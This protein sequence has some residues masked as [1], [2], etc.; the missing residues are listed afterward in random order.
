MQHV[1]TATAVSA[2]PRA[3]AAGAEIAGAPQLLLSRAHKVDDRFDYNQCIEE[4]DALALTHLGELKLCS[5]ETAVA[6]RG[7]VA[8]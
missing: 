5:L 7:R 1:V 6:S 3:K 2:P 8:P 4:L